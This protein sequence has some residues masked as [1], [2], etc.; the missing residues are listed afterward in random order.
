MVKI[1]EFFY[2]FNKLFLFFVLIKLLNMFETMFLYNHIF[3][4]NNI[5]KKTMMRLMT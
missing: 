2:I 3:E 4:N 5:V 1:A